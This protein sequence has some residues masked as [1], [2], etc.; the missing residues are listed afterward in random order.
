MQK[1]R[2]F[3]LGQQ[4]S[5]N[6][7]QEINGSQ[8][9]S[10]RVGS[11]AVVQRKL[12]GCPIWE[13]LWKTQ[14]RKARNALLQT[15]K[16]CEQENPCD[17]FRNYYFSKKKK[18]LLVCIYQAILLNLLKSTVTN[19]PMAPSRIYAEKILHQSKRINIKQ[20]RRI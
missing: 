8:K 10:E 9:N 13:A 3:K 2:S 4:E 12:G 6:K 20:N 16:A 5:Q 15:I 1:S 14:G 17:C 19:L 7:T 11:Q 18:N